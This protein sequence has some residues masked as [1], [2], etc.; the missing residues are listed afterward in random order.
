MSRLSLFLAVSS[1]LACGQETP[2]AAQ[3]TA[4]STTEATKKATVEGVV[5]NE[6]TKEPIRRVEINLQKQGRGGNPDSGVTD[7]AGKF[8]IENIDSGDY[9]VMLRKAGFLMTRG[10]CGM[11]ARIL[12]VTESAS[13]TGLRYAL[14][15][16]AI[17]TGRVVD[18]DGEPVQNAVVILL[19]YRYDRGSYRASSAGRPQQTNDRGEFR[20]TDVQSGEYYLMADARRMGMTGGAPPDAP[21]AANAPRTAFVSRYFPNAP[22]FAQAAA[23]EVQPGQELSG[24]DI[25]LRKEKVVKVTGEVPDASGSP[26]RQAVVTFTLA[27]G[28]GAHTGVTAMVDDKGAFAADNVPP[29][30]YNARAFKY[31]GP[32]NEQSTDTPVSVGDAGLEGVVLQIQPALEAKGA[33]VL[34][35]AERKD[36]DFTGF[37]VKLRSASDEYS[38]A[39]YAQAKT[40]GTFSM[41]GIG[42]GRFTV[43]VYPG[44]GAGYVKSILLGSE[45][46]YGKEVEGAAVA[47]GGLK[48]VIRLDAAT[49]SGTVEIPEERKAALK[50]PT[51]VLLPAD[52]R[53]REFDPRHVAQ[54]NQNNGYELKNLRPGDYI[55]CA[56]EEYDYPALQDPEVLATIASK[57]TKVTLAA[58]ESRSLDLKILPWPE[59]FADRLQ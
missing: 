43:S 19:R 18:D 37:A 56:F 6:I 40:D 28:T 9:S 25:A 12:K 4:P 2:S 8:R 29:G 38:Y 54:L 3:Q 34:E 45:D 13:L 14:R 24:R 16:Q 15:P 20:F 57:S 51:I 44:S 50:S 58:S 23:I 22:E 21:S 46:V 53:L 17:V 48:I 33:F 35:G 5:V 49:L 52:A 10:Y 11:S 30:Q 1:V 26:A 36:F 41:S 47:A 31:N 27:D 7:A 32:D 42:P 59:Q 55:A 39:G